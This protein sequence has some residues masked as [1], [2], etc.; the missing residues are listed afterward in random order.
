MYFKCSIIITISVIIFCSCVSSPKEGEY[1][2]YSFENIIKKHGNPKY[3]NIYIVDNNI[4]LYEIDPNYELYFSKEELEN[5][6]L[7]RKLIWEK[8][9]NTRLII[10]LKIVNGQWVTFDSL[11]Y[12]SKYILF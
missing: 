6:V 1:R 5:G 3:D 2:N 10:W 9:F 7:I 4:G 8:S 11:E 12:N